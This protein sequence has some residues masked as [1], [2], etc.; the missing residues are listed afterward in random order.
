MGIVITKYEDSVNQNIRFD[1]STFDYSNDSDTFDTDV[2]ADF[3][4]IIL[5]QGDNFTLIKET[6]TTDGFGDVTA[7][8]DTEYVIFGYIRD[9]IKRDREV[10]EAGLAVTGNMVFYSYAEYSTT[11]AGVETTW[12]VVEGDI[13]K[14]RDGGRWRVVQVVQEPYV[15]DTKIYKKLVVRDIHHGGS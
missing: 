13:I 7:V 15:Q 10:Q 6:V 11:S 3:K 8:S 2:L 12:E 9:V 1:I 4:A 5:E 14:D